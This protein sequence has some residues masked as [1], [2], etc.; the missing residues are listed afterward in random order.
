MTTNQA[1]AAQWLDAIAAKASVPVA[2]VQSVLDRHGIEPQAT[3]PRRR[4]VT[5]RSVTLKGEKMGT[6]QDGPFDRTWKFG[7]GLWAVLSDRNSRGKSSLLNVIQSSIRGEFPGRIKPDVW[8]WLSHVEAEFDVD[9]V[10]YRIIVEKPSGD[11]ALETVRGTFSRRSGGDDWLDLYQGPAGQHLALAVEDALMTEL[12]FTKFHAFNESGQSTTHSW[13]AISSALFVSG[14]GNAIFGEIRVDA[15]PLRLLQLFMGLPWISTYSAAS[16]AL[17]RVQANQRERRGKPDKATP[18]LRERLDAVERALNGA[19]RRYRPAVDRARLRLDLVTRDAELV[20][21]RN[22]VDE[23]RGQAGAL[24]QQLTGARTILADTR[25]AL[26]QLRDDRAAGVVFRQLK[27]V[28]CPSCETGIDSTKYQAAE[29]AE[30]C[31]VC[32]TRHTEA[33]PEEAIRLVDLEADVEDAAASVARLETEVATTTRAMRAA[34]AKLADALKAIHGIEAEMASEGEAEL[35]LEIRG[36]EAQAEQLHGLIAETEGQTASDAAPD[37]E[38][39][40]IATVA[41]TKS[42]YDG[43]A[44]EILSE[45][46]QEITRLSR[47]FGVENVESMEWGTGGALSIVQG[48]TPTS[49]TKL[50]LGERL[51][52]RIAAALAI[53]AVSRKRQF[54]RHP[55]LLVLDSPAAQEMT[56][57]DFAAL[58]ASVQ[59]A[60]DQTDDIQIIVGAVARP[61]L[62]DVVLGGHQYHA[63]GDSFLF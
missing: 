57:V 37:D 10:A 26:Q 5:V 9:A 30:V 52:V 48:G 6:D 13:P 47:L 27:P 46:S 1:T 17:K 51:R 22:A 7:T 36:L 33:D 38:K 3:L 45:A 40:L 63:E 39:I 49:F 16:T 31:A 12:A 56:G 25:R 35:E 28:C 21:L 32:G 44:R 11:D 18:R 61:E 62:R 50:N 60:I 34:E 42:L 53:I 58:L 43:L 4:R 15:M 54:G 29:A 24:E 55:G 20:T 19:R 8:R 59:Q 23:V 2:T 14:P 41:V